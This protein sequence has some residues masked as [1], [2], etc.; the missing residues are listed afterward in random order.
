MNQNNSIVHISL[1]EIILCFISDFSLD[2]SDNMSRFRVGNDVR[3]DITVRVKIMDGMLKLPDTPCGDDLL[4]NYYNDGKLCYAV[5]KPG[6]AGPLTVTAY[7]SDFSEATVYVNEKEHPGIV[8]TVDKVLQLFPIR[9]LLVNHNAMV[10]HSS[11]IIVSGKGILFTAPSGTGKS[12]QA[13]LWNQYENA[14]IV[15]NDRTLIRRFGKDFYTYGYPIDGSSPKCCNQKN[16]LSAIIVLRQG[17]ENTVERLSAIK[18]LK[19]L[20]EQTVLDTWN[21]QTISIINQEWIDLI[22]QHPIYLFTCKPEREAV[23]C[24]KQQLQKDEVI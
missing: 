12:T 8:R 22:K 13:M 4:M 15:C 17:S 2:L 23:V 19:Y 9:Q 1:G 14:E 24:L 7:T 18:T 20:M 21:S 3:A 11:Q 5:A 16:E 10:L 6:T